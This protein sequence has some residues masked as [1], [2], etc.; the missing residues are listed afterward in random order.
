MVG[1]WTVAGVDAPSLYRRPTAP[2]P[3][4]ALYCRAMLAAI[5]ASVPAGTALVLFWY[6]NAAYVS[7][8]TRAEREMFAS[9]SAAV[10]MRVAPPPSHLVSAPMAASTATATRSALVT[11]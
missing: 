3:A 2:A 4:T 1:F 7:L 8:R 10:A 11:N 6:S 9:H 5:V